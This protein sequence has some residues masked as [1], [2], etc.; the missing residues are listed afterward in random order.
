MSPLFSAICRGYDATYVY[1]YI[2]LVGAPSCGYKGVAEDFEPVG[3][4]RTKFPEPKVA[5]V[6]MSFLFISLK[7]NMSHVQNPVFI[8]LF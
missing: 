4:G 2:Y 3:P 1:I 6:G 7:T 8:P 5:D